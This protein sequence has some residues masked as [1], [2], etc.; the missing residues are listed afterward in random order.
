MVRA[1][2]TPALREGRE[3]VLTR[4]AEELRRLYGPDLPAEKARRLEEFLGAQLPLRGSRLRYA[5][6]RPCLPPAPA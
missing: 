2:P 3:R 6:A 5:A 1:G 4:Q